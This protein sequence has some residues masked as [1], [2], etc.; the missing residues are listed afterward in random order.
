MTTFNGDWK[1]EDIKSIS[2]I[3][4]EHDERYFDMPFYNYW[5]FSRMDDGYI[6][7]KRLT[8][9]MGI[10]SGENVADIVSKLKEYYS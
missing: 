6:I 2:K 7:A 3:I 8:W 1:E 5:I 9:D 4:R 10:I